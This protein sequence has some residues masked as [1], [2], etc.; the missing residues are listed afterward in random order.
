MSQPR[1]R[2]PQDPLYDAN[3]KWNAYKVD[4]HCNEEHSPDEWDPK[5][6]GKI[7]DPSTRHQDKVLDKFVMIIL[8]HLCVRYLTNE[9]KNATAAYQ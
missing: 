5:T 8:V 1:Q 3:D 4:L 7:A 9:Q 2:D 6:E